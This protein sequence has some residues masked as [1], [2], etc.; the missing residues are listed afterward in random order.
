MPVTIKTQPDLPKT[1]GIMPVRTGG[2]AGGQAEAYDL[3]TFTPR[4][5]ETYVTLSKQLY[6]SDRYATALKA[7]LEDY[8]PKLAALRPGVTLNLP[9]A[10]VLERRFMRPIEQA[11]RIE[12]APRDAGVN[13]PVPAVAKSS[14]SSP[15]TTQLLPAK[16]TAHDLTEEAGP[17]DPN[18]KRYR[19]RQEETLYAI[20]RKTLGTGDRWADIYN[21]NKDRLRGSVEV[22]AGMVLKLPKDAKLDSPPPR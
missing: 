22:E 9:P 6:G 10:E 4:P 12:P 19:V 21:L 13:R 20:A 18:D 2:L 17:A 3:V 11:G 8:E 16:D 14:T 15:R 7:Y 1:D 5:G